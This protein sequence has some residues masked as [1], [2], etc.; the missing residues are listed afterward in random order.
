V[1]YIER[2]LLKNVIHI[3][4]VEIGTVSDRVNR[5]NT[6]MLEKIEEYNEILVDI[7]EKYNIF[8]VIK[9]GI[10]RDNINACTIDGYLL[11]C[12][13]HYLLANLIESKL[14]QVISNET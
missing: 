4:A 1:A 7:S 8:N 14:L 3:L 6:Q 9:F 11:N 10:E 12:H 2:A 5:A 13:E